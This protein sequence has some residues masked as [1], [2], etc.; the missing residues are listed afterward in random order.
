MLI[1]VPGSEDG[2][3]GVLVCAENFIYFKN[4]DHE[5]VVA[6]IPRRKDTPIDEPILIVTCATHKQKDLFFFLLQSEFGDLYK[7]KLNYTGQKV[8]DIDIQYFD[9]VPV[10]S[11]MV[12][13][14][15]GFLFVAA[16][17]GNH[18]LYQFLGLEQEEGEQLWEAEHEGKKWTLFQPR[19]LK[20]LLQIDELKSL[21][22]LVDFKVMDLCRE[23]TPQIYSFCGRGPRSSLRVLR[24]GLA[25]AEMAVSGLP[26]NPNAV[27]TVKRNASDEFD[28]Y[29]VVSLPSATLVLAVGETV[30]EVTDSGFLGTTTT[31]AVSLIGQDSLLQIHPNGIRLVRND[32]RIHEWQPPGKRHI[33]LAAANQQQ[34]VICL[35][36]STGELFYFELD[37]TGQLNEIERRE[38]GHD[39]VCLDI[40]PVSQGQRARFMAIGDENNTVRVLSL[41]PEMC[42][43]QVSVQAIPTSPA[44]VSLVEMPTGGRADEVQTLFLNVGLNNGIMLR[45]VVDSVSG[46]LSDTRTRFVGARPVRL[47][48]I[49]VRGVAG[50]MAMSSRSWLCYHYQAVFQ[51][52]PLSYVPLE[53]AA[54]FASQQCPEGIVAV[55]GNTLRIVTVERLA[56]VFNQQ[57][58]PLKYT[59]HKVVVHPQTNYF[60]VIEADHATWD[61]QRKAQLKAERLADTEGAE[62][63]PDLPEATFGAYRAP[64]GMWASCIRVLDGLDGKTHHLVEL[65]DSEAAFSVCLCPF[66]DRG[67]ELFLCV[68]TVKE[69]NMHTRAFT[70]GFLHVYRFIDGGK[71][72]EFMHKTQVELMPLA[73]TAFQGRLLVGMGPA[74]RIY[75]LGK[76]KLLRKCETKA[77]P[78]QITQLHTMGDRVVVGDITESFLYVKYK[79]QENKLYIFADDTVPRWLTCGAMVDYDTMVGADK[80]GSVFVARLPTEVS[81]EV[82]DDPTGSALTFDKGT[83]NGAPHKLQQAI[84]FYVGDT[85]TSLTKTTLVPGVPECILY[86]TTMGALGAF[87]PFLSREDVDFFQHLE[88]YM[89]AEHP[90]LCGRD[91]MAFRSFYFPVKDV[92]DGDLCEQFSVLEPSKQRAIAQELD[93]T[94]SEVLKKLEDIRHTRLF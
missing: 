2:P 62:P 57:E 83:L 59:P 93:R 16:E 74:L 40:A 44:S 32:K 17:F 53:Y 80:F 94:P 78:N 73:L 35:A 64:P 72:L 86:G 34:V 30:E 51:M 49:R 60:I 19:P 7:V 56:D 26:A 39:I 82:D 37:A 71:R 22:P 69:L 84:Q 54:P 46:E 12:V 75:D 9:T 11:S 89:R 81:D 68:G 28:K 91:H 45:T 25:V 29:I 47:H 6:S 4:Q 70:C 3:G 13:L 5:D 18:A 21:S 24:H 90:P 63:E 42:L 79:R 52:T 36:G 58:F 88:M 77:F 50:L 31:L 92:V 85:I 87:I 1:S 33:V 66:H 38:M 48:K 55:S 76:K 14:R 41:Q 15:T 23:D 20:N 43:Q 67:D 61:P 8:T 65:S 10:S 27:W